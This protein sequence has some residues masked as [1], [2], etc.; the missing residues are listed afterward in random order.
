MQLEAEWDDAK[1]QQAVENYLVYAHHDY[2][3][4]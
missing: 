3:N 1:W 2:T 4:I